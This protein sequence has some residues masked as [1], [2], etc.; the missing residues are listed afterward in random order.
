LYEHLIAEFLEAMDDVGRYGSEKYGSESFQQM[1]KRGERLRIP[2]THPQANMTHAHDH[3]S[4]AIMG[5]PHDHFGTRKHQLA[6]VAFNAMM[7]FYLSGADSEE[8][9]G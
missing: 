7:E 2:R 6:A 1:A 4:N 8:S 9:H 3:F 5:I